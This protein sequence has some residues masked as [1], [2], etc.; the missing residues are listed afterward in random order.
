M[1]YLLGVFGVI[2]FVL[3]AFFVFDTPD[4]HPF[5]DQQDLCK[6]R[7]GIGQET[8]HNVSHALYIKLLIA[9]DRTSYVC[10]PVC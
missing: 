7:A 6:L 2:W 4:K 5:I 9:F 10:C 1:Y 8:S 3:W